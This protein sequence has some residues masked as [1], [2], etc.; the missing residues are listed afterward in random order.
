M[1]LYAKCLKQYIKTMRKQIEAKELME[2]KPYF[3][4]AVLENIHKLAKEISR[5][6]VNS[7]VV[8]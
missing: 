5:E 6:K 3:E 4:K 2:D 7:N 8:I 1:M